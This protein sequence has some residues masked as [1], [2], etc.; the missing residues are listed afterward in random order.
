MINTAKKIERANLSFKIININEINFEEK[1]DL[2]F[3]NA[4]LHWVKDHKKLLKN[5]FRALKS[6]GILR[7]NFAKEGNCINFFK[8]VKEVINYPKFKKYFQDFRWPW[9]IPKL[10]GYKKL[11]RN[12]KFRKTKIW[13]ENRD[14]Y[15][16]DKEELTKWLDQSSLVP[17]L[18]EID[19][20]EFRD[21]VVEKMTKKTI[22]KDVR[23]FETFRRIN[24]YAKK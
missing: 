10:E 1:V 3:S 18:Q 2:I 9:Y 5:C 23:C 4:A 11:I 22:Q 13:E 20:K 24:I 21:L 16:K 19:K 14:T 6:N 7:F 15:F 8:I 12:F 17:L